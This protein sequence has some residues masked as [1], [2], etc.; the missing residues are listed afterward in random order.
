MGG[1]SMS[2]FTG[3]FVID[4]ID[5]ENLVFNQN[6]TFC[7]QPGNLIKRGFSVRVW[8]E[9]L[10]YLRANKSSCSPAAHILCGTDRPQ[11]ENA[12]NKLSNGVK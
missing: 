7:W 10:I 8:G 11:K 12:F 3:L 4:T 5:V 2:V 6:N 1:S 9:S